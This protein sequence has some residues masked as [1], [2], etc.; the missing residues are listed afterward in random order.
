MKLFH[1]HFWT[2]R[3]E[4]TENYYR[5]L[6][7]TVGSRYAMEKGTVTPYHPP[8]EWEDFRE[9][10]LLFRIIEVRRGKVN[11]TFGAG[12]KPIFDHIGYLVSEEELEH[13]CN[14][15]DVMGWKTEIGARRT[16]I[17]TPYR[18][19]IELQ[20]RKETV[21]DEKISISRMMIK[22]PD[23]SFKRDLE[24]LFHR[25]LEEIVFEEG[26]QLQL[27]EVWMYGVE[28]S[29]KDPNK[30]IVTGC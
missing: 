15:A 8:L 12:K 27:Q 7:F 23:E 19:K 5:K 9:N 1:Y 13:I 16:F 14:R 11:I 25:N 4:E 20:T 28:G 6:G 21:N 17:F 2:D 3:V 22:G 29:G 18:F 30:V 10:A 26:E 24:R